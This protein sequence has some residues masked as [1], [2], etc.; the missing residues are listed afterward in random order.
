VQVSAQELADLGD[1]RDVDVVDEQ[2]VHNC[3]TPAFQYHTGS[4]KRRPGRSGA[5]GTTPVSIPHW[6]N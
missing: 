2:D 3:A 6:F 5:S 4:I 1:S